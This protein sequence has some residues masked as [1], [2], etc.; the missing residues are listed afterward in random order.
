MSE[1]NPMR[2]RFNSGMDRLVENVVKQNL[3][4]SEYRA[5]YVKMTGLLRRVADYDPELAADLFTSAMML[6]YFFCLGVQEK[7]YRNLTSG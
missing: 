4:T 7:I 2:A 5:E 6:S 3:G 1:Q